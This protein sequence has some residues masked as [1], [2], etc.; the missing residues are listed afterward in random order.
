VLEVKPVRIV[1]E[2]SNGKKYVLE[3]EEL[4]TFL[5][6]ID[7]AIFLLYTHGA[8]MEKWNKLMKKIHKEIGLK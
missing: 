6:Y 5:G 2:Y 7:E 4:D 1:V 3:G 8:D